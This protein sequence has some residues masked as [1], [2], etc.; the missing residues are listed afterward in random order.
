MLLKIL[1]SS[2]AI[3]QLAIELA[4]LNPINAWLYYVYIKPFNVPDAIQ[5][6]TAN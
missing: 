4:A 1:Y 5:S 3:Q 6:A 2:L